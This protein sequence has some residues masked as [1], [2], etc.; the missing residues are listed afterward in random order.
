MP[1]ASL[2]PNILPRRLAELL[3]Q[4][5]Q[6]DD[7]RAFSL[8]LS[9]GAPVDGAPGFQPPLAR[10][11]GLARVPMA[12]ALLDAG[13]DPNQRLPEARGQTCLQLCCAQNNDLFETLLPRA[14]LEDLDHE[15]TPLWH[16]FCWRLG[17][18]GDYV[19]ESLGLSRANAM[20]PLAENQFVDSYSGNSSL[21]Y[22]LAIAHDALREAIIE[23]CLLAPGR[24]Q[25]SKH[26]RLSH[27]VFSLKSSRATSQ[28]ALDRLRRL[29]ISKMPLEAGDLE[30]ALRLAIDLNDH[31]TF[32]FA[33]ELGSPTDDFGRGPLHW[34]AMDGS[35]AMVSR[36]LRRLAP[37]PD[38]AGADALML[39]IEANNEDA[40]MALL[41]HSDVERAD[42]LG[43]SAL[44]KAKARGLGAIQRAIQE[45]LDALRE[46]K[47]LGSCARAAP[48]CSPAA[49]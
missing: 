48:S 49:L 25:S 34:A 19:E 18:G 5:I 11:C 41:P 24:P 39:A 1:S 45:R 38:R 22:A 10:A 33:M 32:D 7:M 2:D 8:R 47:E 28:D 44:D 29:A 23:A 46:R 27:T 9:Q 14:R 37:T 21:D 4:A 43:E 31:E 42:L 35:A 40:A 17:H 13:A 26:R 6:D 16:I 12:L 3:D 20:A 30:K 36:A 15:G